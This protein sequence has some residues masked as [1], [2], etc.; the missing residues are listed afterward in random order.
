M[1]RLTSRT[2]SSPRSTARAPPGMKSACRSIARRTSWLSIEI[3]DSVGIDSSCRRKASPAFALVV[4]ND[5]ERKHQRQDQIEKSE[6][7]QG[8]DHIGLRRVRHC[9]DKCELEHAETPWRVT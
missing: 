6:H 1:S 4:Q 3:G 7:Q 2:I 8:G 5:H 9:L